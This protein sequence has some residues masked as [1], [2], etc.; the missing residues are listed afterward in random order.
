[1]E[2]SW[3][4]LA[5]GELATFRAAITFMEGLTTFVPAAAVHALLTMFVSSNGAL[6]LD[7]VTP[8]GVH[9]EIVDVALDFT[10]TQLNSGNV[11][12][13]NT[14]ELRAYWR[15]G[16]RL[17]RAMQ[18]TPTAAHWLSCPPSRMLPIILL[19]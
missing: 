12:G 7:A 8:S 6:S 1:M 14:S 19:I 11:V 15:A 18:H 2:T 4:E 5:V 13:V 17:T 10:G 3:A 9:A 16:H